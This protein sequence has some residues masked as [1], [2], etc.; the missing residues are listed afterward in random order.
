MAIVKL[1]RYQTVFRSS[2]FRA[3]WL[4]FTA[5][6]IGD[7]MTNVALI[8]YV[9]QATHAPQ[10]VGLLLLCYTG[11]VL[12][13][14]LLAGSLLD[15]F[16]Q[17]TVMLMDTLFRGSVVAMIPLLYALGDLALWHFYVVAV[18]YGLFYMIALA[19]GPTLI[20]KL[21]EQEQLATANALETL[22]YTVSGVCGPP[23]AGLLIV[24]LGAP[25]VL[26][27]D[28]LSYAVFALAL[29]R[30]PARVGMASPQ[31][32]AT[33][34]QRV[35]VSDAFLLVR[36]NRVLLATTL[37]Y[38]TFNVG[39]GFLAVWLPLLSVR[40][41]GGPEVYGLCLGAMAIGE[42]GGALL[43]GSIELPFP[44]G[45]LICL[46][47]MLSGAS[48]LLLLAGLRL[49][50]VLPGLALFGLFSAPL[51]IWAQTLRMQII[52]EE[53][54]GRTFALLRTLMQGTGPLASALAGVLLPILGLMAM[55]GA[56]VLLVGVPG[57][58]GTQVKA[59]RQGKR[60]ESVAPAI[61]VVGDG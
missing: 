34:K 28:A 14:G 7:A 25:N 42:V 9:Y 39:L 60:E 56:S 50:W 53:L 55:V 47:Q 11:P 49:W 35:R 54:R 5:S 30:I 22:S 37:M 8:W 17:R 59:L 40:V 6:A 12:L 3:F 24:W 4:G 32:A 52:P 26:A 16:N 15:R 36:S 57:L 43:A 46:A 45:T 10:A 31:H 2:S 18:I 29:M 44:L 23:I 1:T 27:L 13:G 20:P 38:M 33:G 48:L 21:V 51:T 58:V 19:G 61:E 41:G